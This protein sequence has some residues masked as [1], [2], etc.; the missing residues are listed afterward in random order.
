MNS[1]QKIALLKSLSSDR[2]LSESF[3]YEVLEECGDLK[4]NYSEYASTH[5]IDCDRELLRLPTADYDTCCALI[6]M[7]LREDHFSNGSFVRRQ[8]A[9]HVKTIV[10]RM[11]TL[12]DAKSKPSIKLFSEK[13]VEQ[14]NGF[15][16]YALIDSRNNQVFYIGKGIGNRVFSH[17]IESEKSPKSEKAKL[18]RIQE[19]EAAGF[20][21]NRVIVNWSMTESEAFAAEAALINMLSFLSAD[22][23]TNAVAGHHVHEAMTVED[24]DLL[25]G[26]EH[27]KQ[28]DIQHS[29]MVI[30]INKLYRKGMNPKELYDI[31]RGNWRASMA[32]IQ[33]RN[34]E[35]V[36]GV[37]N[38]LIVAVY[39]PDEW[40][41]VHDRIDVPQIDDLDEETLERGKD[42]VYFVCQDYE[43]LDKNQQFYLHKSIADL[44]VN[45]SSQNPITYLTPME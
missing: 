5:P 21:V 43:H 44:K 45:Q 8:R 32:S 42:R 23:L 14:L 17:E 31:I 35:Y 27:L 4:L 11:I 18:K 38:Q 12:L 39:K 9:G 1:S 37:Y 24:F 3:F 40:H 10:D 15:Y 33:K 22:M 7:L 34:V 30:K 13:A 26:A 41:Y 36:F 25:Y 19:I 28:E 20:D 6:T 29:I 2:I 16:V